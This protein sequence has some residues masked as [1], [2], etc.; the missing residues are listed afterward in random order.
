MNDEK[1]KSMLAMPKGKIHAVIDSDTYNEVDDQFAI[2]YLLRCQNRIS[3]DAIYAAPFLN[4]K[5]SSVKEGMECSFEEANRILSFFP[6]EE[7]CSVF[8]GAGSFLKDE[9]K[10]VYSLAAEDLIR[11]SQNYSSESPLYVV[12]IAAATNIASALLMEPQLSERIVVIWLGGSALHRQG[13][14][15]F[16]MMEDDEAARILFAS[17][18]PLVHVPCWGLAEHF[19]V[20]FAELER[21]LIGK[22]DLSDYLA[23]A[24]I[25]EVESYTTVPRWT[26]TIWDVVPAAWLLDRSGTWT[27]SHLMSAPIP[28]Q[29]GTYIQTNN[30]HLIRYMDLV[31]R[32]LLMNDLF[33]ALLK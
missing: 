6:K 14:L 11:R 5:V 26:K 22:N 17:G 28:K 25:R 15:E 20:S 32:D 10:P 23:Q 33:D 24:V 27:H 8:H 16:N 29:D 2:A 4:E 13:E 21:Y 12:G 31:E 7:R 30:R 19:T 3:V 9:S 18:V 1:R